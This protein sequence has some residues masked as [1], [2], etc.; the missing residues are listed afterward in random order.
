MQAFKDEVL[1]RF[2]TAFL[3]MREN[4]FLSAILLFNFPYNKLL[5]K[6]PI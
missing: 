5:L 2:P 3:T 6:L 4:K 1:R